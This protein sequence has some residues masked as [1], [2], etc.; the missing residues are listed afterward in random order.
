[1]VGSVVVE[2]SDVLVEDRCGVALVVDQDAVGALS[3]DAAHESLGGAVRSRC[4]GWSLH[5][6]DA[7]AGKH[8]VEG[9]GEIRVAVSD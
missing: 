2:V 8:G 7:F 5:G 9:G 6:V 1:L 4:A 3:S